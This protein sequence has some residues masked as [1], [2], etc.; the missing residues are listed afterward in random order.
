MSGLTYPQESKRASARL[1][2]TASQRRKPTGPIRKPHRHAGFTAALGRDAVPI[3]H[4]AEGHGHLQV[5]PHRGGMMLAFG[6]LGWII[7]I[8]AILAFVM[9]KSDLKHMQMGGMDRSGEAMT[10]TGYLLGLIEIIVM[11]VGTVLAGLV[12]ILLFG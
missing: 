8:F 4:D 1:P 7:P 2:K 9:A 6:S 11:C 5:K 12:V 3:T 10:R